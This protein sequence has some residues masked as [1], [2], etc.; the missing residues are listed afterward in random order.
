M[1]ALPEVVRDGITGLLLPARNTRAWV[2]AA[3]R[4]GDSTESE[5]MGEAGWNLWRETYSPEI[6]LLNI[7]DAYRIVLGSGSEN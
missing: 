2:E 6:G 3:E 4:L 5:R 1:G 7:V